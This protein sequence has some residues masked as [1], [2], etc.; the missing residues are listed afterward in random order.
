MGLASCGICFC[1]DV[2]SL[3]TSST[4]INVHVV[5]QRWLLVHSSISASTGLP[6]K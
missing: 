4:F 3:S 6:T 2:I 1:V 5:I